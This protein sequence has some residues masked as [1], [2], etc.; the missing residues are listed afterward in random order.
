M[1]ATKRALIVRGGWEGHEP[2]KATE[3]FIPFLE[4]SGYA[5]TVSDGPAVYADAG[6]MGRIDLVVQCVTMSVITKD[7]VAGLR[8]AVAAGTG[9]AGWHGG[10]AD[11]YRESADYLQL[12]GGQFA[13][14]PGRHPD[15]RAGGP[16]DN[17]IPYRVDVLPAAADHPVTD[18]IGSFDLVTEQYWVLSDDYNDV[19][20]TTTLAAQPYSEWTRPVTSP[21]VWTRR[22]G[23]GRVFVSTPGH[24][25]DVLETPVVRTLVERGMLWASR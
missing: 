19:L 20:A 1:T 7:E 17:F 8:A 16:E 2:V 23:S 9:L 3:L 5:I 14:H 12:V 21:A 22:W 25:V 18:G 15:E 10:I 13:C 6:V 11:S 24:S 4:A